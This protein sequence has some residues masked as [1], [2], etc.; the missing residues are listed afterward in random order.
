MTGT[1]AVDGAPTSWSPMMSP[2]TIGFITVVPG[3]MVPGMTGPGIIVVPCIVTAGC[4]TV[5]PEA[6]G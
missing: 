2:A 1:D 5:Q 6:T 3:I 4:E